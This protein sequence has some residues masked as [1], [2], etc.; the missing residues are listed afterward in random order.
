[1]NLLPRFP[2]TA[3]H[4]LVFVGSGRSVSEDMTV[5]VFFPGRVLQLL[6]KLAISCGHASA[7]CMLRINCK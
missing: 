6:N 5:L 2:I 7:Y 3:L 1:M 4:A